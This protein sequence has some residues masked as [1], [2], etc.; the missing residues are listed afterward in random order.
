MA[1]SCPGV[2]DRQSNLLAYQYQKSETLNNIFV[3]SDW[4]QSPSTATTTLAITAEKEP[5]NGKQD[6]NSITLGNTVV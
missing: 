3:L 2:L 5:P 6:G 4:V 1:V